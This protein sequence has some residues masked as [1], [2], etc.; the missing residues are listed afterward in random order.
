MNDEASMLTINKNKNLAKLL[1]KYK[2]ILSRGATDIGNCELL[3][4]HIDIG[5]TSPI[6]MTLRRIIY[7]QQKEVL[8]DISAKEA[9]GIVKK[10]TSSWAFPLVVV[11]KSNDTARI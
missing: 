6:R 4:H 5:D 1:L 3:S 10:S 2:S 9:T 11:R 7:F 8:Q